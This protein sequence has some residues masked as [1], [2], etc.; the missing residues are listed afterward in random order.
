VLFIRLGYVNARRNLAR[1][2]LAVFSMAIAAGFMTYSIAL[3]QGYPQLF[4]AGARSIIGGEIVVYA[5]QFGGVIPEGESFWQHSFLWRSPSSDISQFRPELLRGGYLSSDERATR[6]TPEQLQEL[7]SALP[8]ITFLYPRFQI[9]AFTVDENNRRYTPLVGRVPDLDNLQAEHPRYTLVDHISG[10]WSGS[11]FIDE[12]HN[13]M[14]AVISHFRRLPPG[15][16]RAGVG[17]SITIEVPR[18]VYNRGEPIFLMGEKVSFTLEIIGS[19][20]IHTRRLDFPEG[21]GTD[22]FWAM[23]ELMIPISTWQRI[24]LEIGGREFHPE[25]VTLG[26]Q[27]LSYLEDVVM[28][29]RGLF[30][31]FT[32]YSVP[33]HLR[34]AEARGL[35]EV[36]SS[37]QNIIHTLELQQVEHTQGALPLDLRL[38]MIA[39]IF[40]NAALVVAS[41]LLIMVNERNDE[42][43]ILKAVGAKRSQVVS[44]VLT[45]GALL[46]IVGT[47]IGFVMFRFPA[48]LQQISN[49]LTTSAILHSIA[50]D[51]LVVYGVAIVFALAFSMLPGVRTANLSIMHALR[52]D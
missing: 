35:I 20:R 9:P 18:V 28:E 29:L 42:I 4:R 19:A 24:W 45:E 7:A 37:H 36:N 2:A 1:S 38:P 5:R 48:T 30:P 44:M 10:R 11:W 32:I 21:G 40:G 16:R 49:Q 8:G 50:F 47:T 33:E 43:A 31:Q 14:V 39:L 41:N 51:V 15:S 3:S 13:Q 46:T 27:D 34:Q 22:L 23:P 26:Y 17:D 25:Q 52:Q 12:D 6:F